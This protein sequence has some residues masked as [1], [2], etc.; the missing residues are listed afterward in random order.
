M[1]NRFQKIL[2]DESIKHESM[3]P[4]ESF[5]YEVRKLNIK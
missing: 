5:E 3:T 2:D 1:R 4:E